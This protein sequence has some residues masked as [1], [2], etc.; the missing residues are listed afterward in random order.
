MIN[1]ICDRCNHKENIH[2][3]NGKIFD[4]YLENHSVIYKNQRFILCKACAMEL[5]TILNKKIKECYD[6]FF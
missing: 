2:I 5:E 3:N 1:I 4:E 6:D